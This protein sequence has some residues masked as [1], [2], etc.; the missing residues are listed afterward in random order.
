M[1]ASFRGGVLMTEKYVRDED[2]A[3]IL[4]KWRDHL[5]VEHQI[6]TECETMKELMWVIGEATDGHVVL[7]LP[8]PKE[9]ES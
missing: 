2:A 5:L 3:R 9:E 4:R 6:S 8:K 1:K 7:G